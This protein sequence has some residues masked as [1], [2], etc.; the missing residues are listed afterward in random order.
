MAAGV[1]VSAGDTSGKAIAS[2]VLGIGGFVI[3][4]LVL[5][6]LAIVLGRQAKREIRERPGLGRCRADRGRRVA[7]SAAG[8]GQHQLR[9]RLTTG[10]LAA[11][12][13]GIF[14]LPT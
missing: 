9:H 4:P 14:T 2:L 5:S 7:V 1:H 8:R 3:F 11:M 12:S 6:I 10:S 13:T